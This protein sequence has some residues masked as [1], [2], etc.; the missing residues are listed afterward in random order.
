[1]SKPQN[2]P[3]LIRQGARRRV[4]ILLIAA[5]ALM[6]FMS[7]G[8][9]NHLLIMRSSAREPVDTFLVLGGSIRREIYVSQLATEYPQIPI[10]ISKGSD[11]PCI[12][13]LFERNKAPSQGVWL[14]KCANST[15]GNYMFS[16]P[17]L[18]QW[19]ARHVKI[20][21]SDTHLPRAQWM[22]KIMLGAHGIWPEMEL[23]EES[24]IP[25]NTESLLKTILDLSRAILW[26]FFFSQIW[27]PSC[28]DIVHLPEVD[29]A[30]WCVNGFTCEYQG[31]VDPESLCN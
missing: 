30:S 15:F 6:L 24:G 12:V 2:T 20:L 1:M 5:C 4:K 17:L 31:G 18:T 16:Q 9:V 29:M 21:T 13:K 7:L 3:R 8:L 23:V 22:A 26:A 28:S 14:E 27:Q 11:D 19:G 10:I 25:G